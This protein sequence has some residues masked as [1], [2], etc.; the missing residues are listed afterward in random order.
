MSKKKGM[1]WEEKR[2]QVLEMLQES[3]TAWLLKDIEK[4]APKRGVV[5]QSVKDVVQVRSHH[6][7]IARVDLALFQ[8]RLDIK[9]ISWFSAVQGLVDDGTPTSSLPYL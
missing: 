8:W 7:A 9:V 4:H 2:S 6:R 5:Q 1:S 3:N